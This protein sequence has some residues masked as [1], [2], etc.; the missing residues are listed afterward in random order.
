[1]AVTT[2]TLPYV[3]T[4]PYFSGTATSSL[5]PHVFPV[6]IDGRPYMVDQKSGKFQ[7]GYEQ[8]V[9]DS[10]DISTAP[11]EAAINPGGLWR[12]GQD[13]WHYGA[14]QSYADSAESK[15]YMFYRSKGISPWNKGELHL[16]N[17]TKVAYQALNTS[18]NVRVVTTAN[19]VFIT[20]DTAVKYT[21]NPYATTPTWTAVT[22]LP[23]SVPR[24]IVSDGTNVYL[25]YA[26]ITNAA[27]IWKINS[28]YVASNHAY[29][30]EFGEIGYAKGRLIAGAAYLPA[31]PY[32]DDIYYDPTGNV[33]GDS[34]E[35]KISP[36]KWVGFVGGTN[37]IYAAGVSGDKSVVYKITVSNLGVLDKLVGALEL[38]TGEVI[39]S[40]FSYLGFILIGSNKGVRYCNTDQL[41]NL[42]AGPIIP[43]S[44]DVAGF[45]AEDKFVWFTWSN[46]DGI[47]SGLGRLDLSTFS[48]T[49]TPAFASDLM[50][51]NTGNV[52]S[53]ATFNRK[54]MFTVKGVGLV[55]EDD[56]TLVPS[57]EI[58][59]GT[60]RWGIPDRKFVAKVDTRATPLAGSITP[61][62]RIDDSAWLELGTWDTQNST[63]NSVDGSD[64]RAIE[65]S[66]K[67]VLTRSDS[68]AIGPTMTRWMARAYVAPYRSQF[69][70]IPLLLHSSVK[71]RDKEYFYDVDEH[72]EFFD[73]LI[74][75][76]RIVTLQI[77]AFTHTVIVDDVAWE[78]SDAHGN[79]WDFNGTLVVTLRSVE[80]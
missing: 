20:D 48:A 78:S 58:E 59:T 70:V 38:P 1:M 10:Q 5:V 52:L 25:S 55:V 6:A 44:G 45:T 67:F 13:S 15:D 19:A 21:T 24:D 54:R 4:P 32:G 42:I 11:G 30:H 77:G 65:A 2:F 8:R 60:W 80:N 57:G 23:V 40:I 27:G 47:S 36:W 61:F 26:G 33:T 49:N 41:G 43:T 76:P 69:F 79:A 66:F 31:V 46:Y 39:T 63:E 18:A 71:I 51:D 68:V 56:S 35:V 3:G 34:D 9:R 64:E 72:Q 17:S 14:G 37:A 62:L 53:C 22:G 50:Y 12:R 7:R 28:S 73:G 75:S 16:L 29:G 74:E